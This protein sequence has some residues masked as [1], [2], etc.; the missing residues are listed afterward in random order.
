MENDAPTS[1][2]RVCVIKAVSS[3][4]SRVHCLSYEVSMLC[5]VWQTQGTPGRKVLSK[6]ERE[7]EEARRNWMEE[8]DVDSD[9]FDT[10]LEDDFPPEEPDPMDNTGKFIY[11]KHCLKSGE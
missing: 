8:P 4:P 2:F 11:H 9:E 5:V 7:A 10:D 1:S 3:A 6:S